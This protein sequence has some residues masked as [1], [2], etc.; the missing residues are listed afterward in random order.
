MVSLKLRGGNRDIIITCQLHVDG[1]WGS[2]FCNDEN[3]FLQTYK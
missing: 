3:D 1:G 2:V